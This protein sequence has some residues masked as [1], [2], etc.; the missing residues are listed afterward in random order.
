MKKNELLNATNKKGIMAR[1]V[2]TLMH[3]LPMFEEAQC[4]TLTNAEW[5]E[6]RV[7]NLPSSVIL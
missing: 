4:G 3:K 2:W 1:P 5:L 6:E 7:V